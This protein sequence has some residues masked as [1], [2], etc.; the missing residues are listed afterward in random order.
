MNLAG[1]ALK[2]T[3]QGRVDIGVERAGRR[4]ASTGSPT[5]ASA[6]APS[7][8]DSIFAEFRQVDATITREFGGTGLGLSITQE[9]RRDA[10]RPHL[11]RERAGRGLD[12]LLPVPLR[13]GERG[14]MSEQDDPL[15]RGQRV[16]PQDR[17]PAARP[18]DLSA[19]RGGRRRGRRRARRRRA[20]GPDPD[21]RAAAQDVGARGDTHA[22]RRSRARS[23]SRSSSSRRSR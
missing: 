14:R 8:V 19:A 17:A 5:P 15:R 23:T 16:Q 21:G 2:F 10:R 7:S 1:N 13:V 22:A 4:A 12:L 18:H 11:G 6:F 3:R 9:V 20:A